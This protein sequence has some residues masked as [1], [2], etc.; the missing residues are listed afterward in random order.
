MSVLGQR[1]T[2]GDLTPTQVDDC[3]VRG[4]GQ[5]AEWRLGLKLWPVD[6]PPA[7]RGETNYASVASGIVVC[8]RHMHK[9]MTDAPQFMTPAGRVSIEQEFARAGRQLPDFEGARYL[10]TSLPV[11]RPH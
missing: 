6:M 1:V 5:R 8:D 9:P 4:C 10:F 11:R 7:E 3:S 2:V